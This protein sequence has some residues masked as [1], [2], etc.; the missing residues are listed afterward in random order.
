VE[1]WVILG[2]APSASDEEVARAYRDLAKRF[3]PDAPG[4]APDAGERMRA[5]NAAYALWRERSEEAAARAA[6]PPPAARRPPRARRPVP[7]G[8]L[9]PDVRRQL[10]AELLRALQPT[11][12]VLSIADAATWDSPTVRLVATDRRLLWL[13]DDAVADR[14]RFLP[15]GAVAAL[16]G[17]LKRPRRRTAEIRVLA[18]D[19]RRLAFAAMRPDDMAAVVRAV[20]GAI[21]GR[22]VTAR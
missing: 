12:P 6:V 19:G 22:A 8:W 14:V 4:A 3:H 16:D 21:P 18:R 11:E 1:P 5:I 2:V 15:Y 20:A 10:G 7:G 17:R 13:R 9:A